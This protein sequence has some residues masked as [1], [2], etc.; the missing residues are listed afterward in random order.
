MLDD[1][2]DDISLIAAARSGD[3][4]AYTALYRG[5]VRRALHEA[6]KV[7]NNPA[8]A[9]DCVANAFASTFQAIRNGGGPQDTFRS[10]L[11]AATRNAALQMVRVKRYSSETATAVL[12]PPAHVDIYEIGMDP[13]VRSAFDGLPT[14]WK[15]VLWKTEIEGVAARDIAGELAM[16][17]NSVAALAKRAREGFR[18]AYLTSAIGS[19]PHPWAMERLDAYR[20]GRLEPRQR[21]LFELHLEHCHQCRNALA[22]MPISAASV[23]AILLVGGVVPPAIGV[24]AAAAGG[25]GIVGRIR[26]SRSAKTSVGVAAAIVVAL[27]AAGIAV[28]IGSRGSTAS[29][30][31]TAP[32]VAITSNGAGDGGL[33]G[34][35]ASVPEDTSSPSPPAILPPP[36]VAPT[37][38]E[39][40]DVTTTV[41][42]DPAAS[43]TTVGPSTSTAATRPTINTIRPPVVTRPS[44]TTR[45]TTATPITVR[46]ITATTAPVAATAAS[47]TV[48][49]TAATTTTTTSPP[50]TAAPTTA[51]PTTTTTT[52]ASTTTTVATPQYGGSLTLTRNTP[53]VRTGT[54]LAT[55][56]DGLPAGT[57]LR[58]TFT[59]AGVSWTVT[60]GRVSNCTGLPATL[61]GAVDLPQAAACT[62]PALAIG[63]SMSVTFTVE[64]PLYLGDSSDAIAVRLEAQRPGGGVALQ[65]DPGSC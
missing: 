59:G 61:L 52:I 36:S 65:C 7:V 38:T 9:E 57:Q 4:A 28:A 48:A 45:P 34:P 16:S 14:R 2:I 30:A 18:K 10:Y 53:G 20:S 35:F 23:G 26:G 55:G 24:G 13:A 42:V 58:F 62:S 1:V 6:R 21:D 19:D 5:H 54:V 17:A 46:P 29:T 51:I 3:Q 50:T 63:E 31:S 56:V 39:V 44:A 15:E 12:D 37:T 33:G 11:M 27:A 8:D 49:P 41:D 43:S 40:V 25:S 22:P 64:D 47:S 60:F 32:G